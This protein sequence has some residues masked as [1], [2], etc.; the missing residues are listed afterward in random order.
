M[1]MYVR[2]LV[3]IKQEYMLFVYL[4]LQVDVIAFVLLR[5]TTLQCIVHVLV[6][7]VF[8]EKSLLSILCKHTN[9]ESVG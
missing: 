6:L 1:Y 5:H 7:C 2:V 9:V 8:S 4:K 3:C